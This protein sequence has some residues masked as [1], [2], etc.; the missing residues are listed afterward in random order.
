MNKITIVKDYIR[1]Y[2]K[3]K[4]KHAIHSPFVFEF[5]TNVLNQKKT[6]NK[7]LAQIETLRKELSLSDKKIEISDFGAGS[8]TKRNIKSVGEIVL[9]SAKSKKYAH[10]LYRIIEYYQI[11]HILELGTSSGLTSMYLATAPSAKKVITIEGCPQI[12]K[13]AEEN[14]KKLQIKNIIPIVGNFDIILSEI[15]QK[16]PEIDFVFFDGNHTEEATLRYFNQCLPSISNNSIFI[17]D[18]IN[19][20]EGMKAAWEQIKQNPSVK[21]TIDLFFIGIVFF[22]KELSKEDFVIR[23]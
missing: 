2:F 15:L 13:L 4:T 19:W 1:Y 20:S 9:H 22:R 8:T 17:F 16:N 18:D 21:V 11:G 6:Q 3:S 5:V 23:Y 14:F 10:L 7:Q 12:A